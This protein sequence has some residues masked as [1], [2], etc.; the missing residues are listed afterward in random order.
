[1]ESLWTPTWISQRLLTLYLTNIFFLHSYGIRG[2]TCTWIKDFHSG[3]RQQVLVKGS[4][5]DW[6]PVISGIPQGSV[7]G[8]VLFV[9]FIN[10]LPDIKQCITQM[11]EGDTKTFSPVANTEDKEK[12]QNDFDR[13]YAWSDKWQC[14][15]ASKCQVMHIGNTNPHYNYSIESVGETVQLEETKLEKDLGVYVDLN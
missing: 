12:L 13:L 2:E 5:S 14:F 8:P 9:T 15:N 7:L 1:M 4:Q 10:D 3:R 6:S 11:F